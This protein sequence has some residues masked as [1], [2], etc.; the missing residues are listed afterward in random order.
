M[1]MA[2][3][4]TAAAGDWNVV[5]QLADRVLVAGTSA[6]RQRRARAQARP[7]DRCRRPVDR[8]NRRSPAGRG[9]SGVRD[10]TLLFGYHDDPAYDDAEM[11][12]PA[13]YDEA[14][15][16]TGNPR[17]HYEKILRSVADSG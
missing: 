3:S 5:S 17:P 9:C 11:G 10:L 4:P 6:A 8:R 12:A 7:A 1:R 16:T 14:V 2:A 13:S 15:D